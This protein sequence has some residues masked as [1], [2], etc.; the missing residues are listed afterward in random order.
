VIRQGPWVPSRYPRRV[1]VPEPTRSASEIEIAASAAVAPQPPGTGELAPGVVTSLSGRVRR[2]IAS[3]PSLMTGPGTGTYLVGAVGGDLAVIDPGPDD[4]GH[5]DRI[6]EVGEDRIRWILVTHTH[7]DHSPGVPGL[8]ARTGATVVGFDERDGFVPDVA[9]ADGWSLAVAQ[10]VTLRALHTPGHASNHVCWL[11]EEEGLLF[12][13][14]HVMDGSTVVIA[15]PDGDMAAYLAQLG[16]LRAL[17]LTAIAPGHGRLIADPDARLDEYVEHRRQRERQVLR[18]LEDG[19][20]P[21]SSSSR[22]SIEESRPPST[23]W[24]SFPFGPICA[25]WLPSDGRQRTILTTLP[26]PGRSST[27]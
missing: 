8:R 16:R 5:L 7:P 19:R 6:A 20:G 9:A 1:P 3:N 22:P 25:N 23:R 4:V 24:P 14:D 10:G 13:G 26:P 21:R 15:P 18:A 17:G 2:V 11:L 12:S 27:R